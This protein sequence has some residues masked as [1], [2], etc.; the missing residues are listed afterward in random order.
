MQYYYFLF[1]RFSKY[2][3]FF[4]IV[5][6]FCFDA[7]A[8][9]QNKLFL[10]DS[11]I[12]NIGIRGNANLLVD[13]Q[14]LAGDPRTGQGA[15][16]FTKFNQTYNSIYNPA[17][18]LIKLFEDY[19]LE[20]LWYYDSNGKDTIRVYGGDPS[21][22]VFVGNLVTDAYKQWVSFPIQDTFKFLR[23]DFRHPQ[24][25]INE[26]VLYGDALGTSKSI[27]PPA[28]AS[29]PVNMG[30]LIGINGFVDDPKDLLA[31]AAGTLR[32]YHRWDWDEANGQTNYVGYPQNEYAFSPSWVSSWDFDDYYG[33][34]LEKGVEVAPCLQGSPP[35]IRGSL[36]DDAKPIEAN[37]NPEDPASY[38]EHADYMF[39]F[40]ARYGSNN[41]A[42]SF[43]K[44]RSNQS[45]KSG[46]GLIN[47]LESWT[48]PD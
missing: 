18:I 19:A 27:L 9:G 32:E 43:L 46:L 4:L 40:A 7:T 47:Y 14:T 26:I 35:H 31:N 29:S 36:N 38:A 22:W 28:Q 17:T 2:N 13:E 15:E 11:N 44:L 25:S 30:K 3:F 8:F 6:I 42:P 23:L 34:L 41:V 20:D 12:V 45:P 24:A 16:V 48:S 21:S 1:S 5:F 39:Q 33:A 37:E 10:S